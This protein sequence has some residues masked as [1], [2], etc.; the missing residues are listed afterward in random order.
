MRLSH[1][2]LTALTTQLTT[3]HEDWQQQAVLSQANEAIAYAKLQEVQG[4]VLRLQGT[5][6]EQQTVIQALLARLAPPAGAPTVAPSPEATVPPPPQFDA[7]KADT[8]KFADL[9]AAKLMDPALPANERLSL[10][11]YDAARVYHRLALYFER[12]DY[13]AVR[14]EAVTMYRDGHVMAQPTPG[15]VAGWDIFPDGLYLHFVD[16]GDEASKEALLA[17]SRNAAY[18]QKGE[19]IRTWLGP[20]SAS[21]EAAYNLRTDLL[22]EQVGST[23]TDIEALKDICLGH[24]AK[25]RAI[26]D[27]T[28]ATPNST[29]G[30]LLEDCRCF[31]VGL[32][33]E[34]LIS[35]DA[36]T[37]TPAIR[38]AITETLTLMW[39][40]MYVPEAKA[41]CYTDR[42]IAGVGDRT[43]APDVNL[44]I[45]PAY[46]WLGQRDRADLL[47]EGSVT[48]AFLSGHKQFMQATR[49]VFD[50]L[51]WRSA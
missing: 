25:W 47:F 44:L 18:A 3:S 34:A 16:T 15:A 24:L 50:Y 45:A 11:Y 20:L 2:E 10:Y 13:T 29:Y 27:G 32:T 36:R 40:T 46:A 23:D 21:R 22:A 48:G 28:N 4:D 37:P 6:T 33:C 19:P 5:L 42:A 17:M 31:M 49:W 39:E 12:P 35:Y 30:E 51:T 38:A 8:L 26:L 41:L 14:D 1:D 43:P 9:H 7:W